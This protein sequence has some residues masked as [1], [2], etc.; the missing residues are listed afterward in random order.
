LTPKEAKES[1]ATLLKD[2]VDCEAPCFWGIVPGQTTFSEAVRAITH[3]G[4]QLIFVNTI[5]N[6]DFRDSRYEFESGLSV[7]VNLAIQDNT[8]QNVR[9][10]ITP[11]KQKTGVP[12]AWLAYSPETLIER[13]GPPSRVEFALDWGPRSYFEMDM[14]FDKVDLIVVYEGHNIIPGQKGSPRICPL[15]AQFESVRLWMGKDPYQPPL[16]AVSLEKATSMTLEEFSEVVTGDP[17][18]ACFIVN[19]DAFK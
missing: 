2:P 19:G 11:E 16:P 13:Y 15:S 10:Y 17:G 12:R 18:K 6:K 5:D 4:L 9:V 7:G 14:Y 3:F 1:L 8:V